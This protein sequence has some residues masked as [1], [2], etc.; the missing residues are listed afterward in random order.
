MIEIIAYAILV[1]LFLMGII[2]LSAIIAPKLY[3]K[4]FMDLDK[5]WWKKW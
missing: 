5:G 2:G 1:Y 4:H 3:P